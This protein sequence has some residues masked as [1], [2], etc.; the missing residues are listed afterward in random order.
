MRLLCI[1]SMSGFG[2][3]RF[4]LR[5]SRWCSG[6][7]RTLLLTVTFVAT[8][9]IAAAQAPEITTQ[10]Q[11]VSLLSGQTAAFTVD[12]T[13]GQPM[14]FRWQQNGTNFTGG[15]NQNLTITNVQ[16]RH[17]G[18]YVLIASNSFGTVTSAV[19]E[20]R[21]DEK[22]TFRI[23]SLLTN[24]IIATEGQPFMEDDK[25]GIAVS[26]NNVFVTGG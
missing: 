21:V 3:K 6:A 9:L 10:P 26:A 17:Y 12:V 8:G 24:G 19:A 18:D 11:S 22:L 1:Q 25:G 4:V 2:V 5:S 13:G 20:L 15:T 23:I 16:I 14:S 7:L